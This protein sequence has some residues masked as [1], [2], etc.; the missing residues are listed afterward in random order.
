MC[1]NAGLGSPA[2]LQPGRRYAAHASRVQFLAAS[3]PPVEGTSAQWSLRDR[4]LLDNTP[5][6][7]D[8]FFSSCA[9]NLAQFHCSC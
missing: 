2:N 1:Q 9:Q 3:E 4:V 7:S 5:L 8:D 6:A